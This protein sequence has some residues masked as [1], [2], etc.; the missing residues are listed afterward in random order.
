MMCK[1]EQ[2]T[3]PVLYKR[4]SL[5]HPQVA[6]IKI[7]KCTAVE[8]VLN[9]SFNSLFN[10]S[11]TV[12]IHGKRNKI[13]WIVVNSA[14]KV[15]EVF[16]NKNEAAAF[17]SILHEYEKL[18]A[19]NDGTDTVCVE[20][21][22]DTLFGAIK[23]TKEEYTK[24]RETAEKEHNKRTSMAERKFNKII[25]PALGEL[26]KTTKPAKE[27]FDK[28][29]NAAEEEWQKTTNASLTELCKTLN[30]YEVIN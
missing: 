28:I 26:H 30:K 21:S 18:S 12:T 13:V 3:I 14:I 17:V 23:V 27:K 6:H 15:I 9:Q 2:A 22:I 10:V 25:D 7:I 19:K 1:S 8:G 4:V 5:K 16:Y 29:S 20:R 24:I 11:L